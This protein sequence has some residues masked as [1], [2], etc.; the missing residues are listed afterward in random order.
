MLGYCGECYILCNII[1]GMKDSKVY[2]GVDIDGWIVFNI[3]LD[4]YVGIGGWS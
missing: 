1:M 2:F 4:F 3:I